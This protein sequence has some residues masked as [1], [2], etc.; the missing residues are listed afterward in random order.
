M[1]KGH[2]DQQLLYSRNL[3]Q[4][5]TEIFPDN[6]DFKV[7]S[8]FSRN[9]FYLMLRQG[10]IFY[11]MLNGYYFSMNTEVPHNSFNINY[12][13]AAETS[14]HARCPAWDIIILTFFAFFFFF[15]FIF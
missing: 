7:V 12:M 1:V 8:T 10:C 11:L 5:K 13:N 6:L 14:A 15:I 3:H 9:I 4:L 2:T